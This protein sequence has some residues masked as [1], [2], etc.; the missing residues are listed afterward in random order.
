MATKTASGFMRSCETCGCIVFAVC[1]RSDFFKIPPSV[2]GLLE[3]VA[4]LCAPTPRVR[5]L[6]AVS[7]TGSRNDMPRLLQ[8]TR[9]ENPGIRRL[10]VFSCAARLT[11]AARHAQHVLQPV[12]GIQAIDSSGG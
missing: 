6:R 2:R 4:G 10:P 9:A 3:N 1:E 12:A 11:A 8:N 5:H 7:E